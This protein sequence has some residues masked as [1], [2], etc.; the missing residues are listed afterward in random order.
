MLYK[1]T[2]EPSTFSFLE[3]LSKR[4][5]LIGFDLVGGTALSLQL[6]HR[7]STDLDFFS[8]RDFDNSSIRELLENEAGQL[9]YARM[10]K[11]LVQ[12]TINGIKIDFACHRYPILKKGIKLNNI[13][14]YSVDDIAAMKL[15]AILSRGKKRDF[16]DIA[17]ILND[18]KVT[19]VLELFK[20]KYGQQDTFHVIKSLGYFQDAEED[21]E[22][23]KLVD[24]KYSWEKSKQIISESI[25]M[26]STERNKGLSM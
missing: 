20:K 5:E 2:V 26:M 12:A 24:K 15:A 11:N 9:V 8:I 7:M 22:P 1:E 21:L 14:I 17:R 25:K 4:P 23:L 3:K 6:G 16:V 18:Y 13:D 19:E 10:G